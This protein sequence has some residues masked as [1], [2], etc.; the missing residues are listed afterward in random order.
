[1]VS[2]PS[3]GEIRWASTPQ[4]LRRPFLV[5]H[6]PATIAHLH[7]VIAV[8]ATRTIRG[9]PTEVEL[10]PDDGMPDRCALNL[11]N[12]TLLPKLFLGER[13]TRLTPRRL[14]EVCDA[15]GV[16]TGCA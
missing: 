3:R 2:E 15:L 11:D 1:M 14:R 7:S 10:G 12:L 9:I 5:L 4:G 16:A 6:R 13:I 8:P